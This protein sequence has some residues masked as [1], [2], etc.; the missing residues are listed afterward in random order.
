M[1]GY[2]PGQQELALPKVELIGVCFDGSGRRLGQAAAPARLR[3]AGL[4]SLLPGAHLAS[5]ITVSNPDPTRGPLAGF[6]NERALLELVESVFERTRE[7]LRAGRFPL[8][9][10]GDC[11]VLLGAVPALRDVYGSAGLLFVDGHED[12]TTMEQSTTGEAANMEVAL[13]LGLT[14]R[15]APEPMRSRLPALRPE[16]IVMLGQRDAG[17]RDR[18]G[19][20]S[21][22][23]RVRLA[24]AAEVRRAPKQ[25]AEQAAIQVSAQATDWWLHV[26]L[27]VL[28]GNE[29]R[30][31][32]AATDPSMQEGLTWGQLTDITQTALQTHG[33]RGWSIGVY[34]ADLDLDGHDARRIVSYLGESKNRSDACRSTRNW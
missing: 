34:N 22:A 19:V 9:Y 12:A 16:A 17:Y 3:N 23:D 13:L 27:D 8:L 5:D 32:G 30:A 11:A 18:M 21:I 7:V 29:F 15:Q 14:G 1:V 2:T 28:D 4:T 24:G 33:C 25:L 20:A 6:V 31:C 26:D 10:G